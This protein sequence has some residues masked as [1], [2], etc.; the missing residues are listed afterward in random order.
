VCGITNKTSGEDS[1]AEAVLQIAT[2]SASSPPKTFTR[3]FRS[4][5][6]PMLNFW[7]SWG[8]TVVVS[9]VPDTFGSEIESTQAIAFDK[10]TALSTNDV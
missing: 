1:W 4:S 6:R 8:G 10:R 2:L 5:Q 7:M 9:N 3:Q